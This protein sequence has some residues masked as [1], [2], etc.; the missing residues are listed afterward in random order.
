MNTRAVV[1]AGVASSVVLAMWEMVVETILPS[2]AGFFGA[3]IAI[4]ATIVRNLQGSTNPIPFDGLAL[5]LGLAG[6]MMNAVI[7]AAIFAIGVGRRN[8]GTGALVIA[9]MAWG[10]AVFA[11]M[12]FVV[13]PVVDPLMGNLNA[14]AFVVGHLMWGA[15][16]GFVWAR[17]SEHARSY[18]TTVA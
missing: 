2:G 4:G 16:L 3:P 14:P 1:I 18:M 17:Y 7:L 15:T 8:L 9:G 10:A 5:V 13:V 6:H 11:G 12:W